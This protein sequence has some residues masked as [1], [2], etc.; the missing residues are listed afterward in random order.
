MYSLIPFYLIRSKLLFAVEV[1]HTPLVED[2]D[3]IRNFL[4]SINQKDQPSLN[5]QKKTI[6]NYTTQ[7]LIILLNERRS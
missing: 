3:M 4:I 6:Q 7:F 2:I 5:G 1:D